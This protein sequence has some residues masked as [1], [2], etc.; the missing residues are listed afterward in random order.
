MT[1]EHQGKGGSYIRQPDGTL[2]LVERTEHPETVYA[3]K[4]AA[5]ETQ[6]AVD[7][8]AAEPVKKG[9]K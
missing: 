9:A 1:E 2:K 4:K 7:Q 6:A 5:D 8:P 3:V